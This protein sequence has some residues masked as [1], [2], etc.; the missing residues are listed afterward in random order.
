[1][2]KGKP[3]QECGPHFEPLE[4]RLLL[5]VDLALSTT[6]SALSPLPPTN[7][8]EEIVPIYID[9]PIEDMPPAP[10]RSDAESANP[11]YWHLIPTWEDVPEYIWHYGCSP[12]T[13]GMLLGW[14]D[15]QPGTGDLFDGNASIWWG[16]S[17]ESSSGGTKAMVASDSHII[18][19]SENG[20]TYG[21][22]HNS[23]SYPNHEANPASLADF[24]YTDDGSTS[25]SDIAGGLE[26]FA[27]WDCPWTT[28][29]ESYAATAN[30]Y[31]TASGW[32][33][34]DFCDQIDAG[35]PV[36][37]GITGHSLLA[38]GWWDQST[39]SAPDNVGYVCYTT[40]GGWGVTEFRWDGEDVPDDRA[41]YGATYL[42]V[43]PRDPEEVTEILGVKWHDKDGD[44]LQDAEESGLPGWMIYLDV[45]ANGVLDEAGLSD[46]VAFNSS[47]VPL[48][49]PDNNVFVT[50]DL[51]VTGVDARLSAG[52]IDPR[53]R[54]PIW[55]RRTPT[56]LG[57]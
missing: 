20:K 37:L 10:E 52:A 26:N 46:P 30:T 5:S 29:D 11:S 14:W 35:R 36:H 56:G 6:L 48:P 44:G 16:D 8:I 27:S 51:S 57:N 54:W 43:T 39:P 45:N 47:D 9:G 49:I 7:P 23:T 33:F 22:W 34:Q 1:M 40:W 28:L 41:V 24:M 12:T 53:A 42:D 38:L 31:Y 18:A 17:S 2:R 32:T 13:A 19:G 4:P 50:S 3:L 25:R 15:S 55:M 21:D